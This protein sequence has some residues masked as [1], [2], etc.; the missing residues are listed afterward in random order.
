MFHQACEIIDFKAPVFV[1]YSSGGVCILGEPSSILKYGKCCTEIKYL[2]DG[3]MFFAAIVYYYLL[4]L[5]F[6]TKKNFRS[7]RS[8]KHDTIIGIMQNAL[9][10]SIFSLSQSQQ[11]QT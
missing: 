3:S 4:L 6:D 7:L 11:F 1:N 2:T 10:L 5:L 9:S 8:Q